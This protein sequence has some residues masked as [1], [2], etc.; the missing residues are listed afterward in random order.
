MILALGIYNILFKLR[1]FSSTINMLKFFII[2]KCWILPDPFHIDNFII[3]ISFVFY[4]CYF[5]LLNIMYNRI[6]NISTEQ[7]I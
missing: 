3:L 2:T 6:F 4:L 5:F 7:N 1:K